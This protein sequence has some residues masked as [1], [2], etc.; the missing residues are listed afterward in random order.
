MREI[1]DKPIFLAEIGASEVGEHKGTWTTSLFEA[2]AKPENADIVGLAWFDLTVTSYVE[3]ERATDDWRIASRA[4]S[5]SAFTAGLRIP[6]S[7][8]LLAA[9]TGQ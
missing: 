3:G 4:D 1:T 5:L 7:G 2:L 9:K 6:G 8:F